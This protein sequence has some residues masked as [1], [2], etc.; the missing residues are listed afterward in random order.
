MG[1]TLLFNKF[2]SNCQSMP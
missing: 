1:E 2:C